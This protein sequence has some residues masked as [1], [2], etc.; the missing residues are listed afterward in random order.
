MTPYYSRIYNLAIRKVF[1]KINLF[2]QSNSLQVE[3]R[4][5]DWKF[6][7]WKL[8]YPNGFLF[9][10]HRE[11]E[12]SIIYWNLLNWIL[13]LTLFLIKKNPMANLIDDNANFTETI[14]LHSLL[15]KS[16]MCRTF[17]NNCVW[18]YTQIG[19][20]CS[21]FI[22]NFILLLIICGLTSYCRCR[23]I[24]VSNEAKGLAFRLIDTNKRKH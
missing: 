22:V 15:S 11:R 23:L 17:V 14:V 6:F 5:K 12:I 13:H 1:Y 4:R 3:F 8:F 21:V 16:G 18:T 2:K 20:W 19:Y 10:V 7:S 9:Y 24:S